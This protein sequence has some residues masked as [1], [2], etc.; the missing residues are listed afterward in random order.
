[1]NIEKVKYLSN[2]DHEEWMKIE[3]EHCEDESKGFDVE[4]GDKNLRSIKDILDKEDLTF[5]LAFGTLLGA[6]R[7][8]DWIPYDDDVDF[9]MYEEDLLPKYD[10]LKDKFISEGF[11]F[12]DWKKSR[13]TKLNLYRHKQLCTIDALA[14]DPSYKNNKYRLTKRWQ[15]PKK[16]FEQFGDI[17]FRGMNFRVPFPPEDFLSF[18]Y[19]DW[20]T[21]INPKNSSKPDKWRNKKIR[22]DRK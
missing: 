11:I 6:V 12:R 17:E 9:Y 18:I 22:Q 3:R 1:M 13:G 20:K 15:F 19:R 2:I 7:N 21:P 4:A 5:W 10:I 14:L 16:H 8:K